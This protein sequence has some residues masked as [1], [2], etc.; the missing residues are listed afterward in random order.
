MY[1]SLLTAD[2]QISY[3]V[4]TNRNMWLQVPSGRIE[5]NGQTLETSDGAA[6]ENNWGDSVR[7][8]PISLGPNGL[9]GNGMCSRLEN[10]IDNPGAQVRPARNHPPGP[11]R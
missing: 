5:L 10:A 11:T 8:V 4:A 7:H 2:Q 6:T 1:L 3:S 9:L